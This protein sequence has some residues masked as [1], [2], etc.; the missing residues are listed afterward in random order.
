MAY[1]D[2]PKNRALWEI[3]LKKLREEKELRSQNK[4][5][6]LTRL[7]EERLQKQAE[8]VRKKTSYK[9]LVKEE[10]A[11]RGI[12]RFGA[13]KTRQLATSLK[14]PVKEGPKL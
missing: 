10:E 2:S 13:A 8:A 14:Q 5:A 4:G 12:K 11:A 1:F 6:D 3:E 7:K 9:E